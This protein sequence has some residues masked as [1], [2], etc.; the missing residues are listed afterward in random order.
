ML[1]GLD[2]K[3]EG[4]EVVALAGQEAFLRLDETQGVEEMFLGNLVFPGVVDVE[5]V[6]FLDPFDGELGGRLVLDPVTLLEVNADQGSGGEDVVPHFLCG[7]KADLDPVALRGDDKTE[8]EFRLGCTGP[9]LTG[10]RVLHGR[11]SGGR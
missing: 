11:E 8:A 4:E 5:S 6:P 7:W 1:Q 10:E 9:S 3:V 2:P